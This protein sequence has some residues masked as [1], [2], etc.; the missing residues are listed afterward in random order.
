MSV[1]TIE[2]AIGRDIVGAAFDVRRNT[3]RG[4]LEK[5]YENAL[6]YELNERGHEVECQVVIPA[7]YKGKEIGDA[8]R[9][10]IIVDKKVIIEL[11]AISNMEGIQFCQLYTYLK[12]SHY[13][14]G[15]LINFGAYDFII[16]NLNDEEPPYEFGI[17]PLS[18]NHP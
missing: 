5:F 12:L 15:Y 9:A 4:M 2:R 13:R 11:K 16:G 6:A 3:G 10:D 7:I 18:N 14:L 17:Y 8:Y 1:E